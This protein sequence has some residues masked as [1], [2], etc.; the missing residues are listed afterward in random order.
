[1][2]IFVCLVVVLFL[3]A[4]SVDLSLLI[5]RQLQYFVCAHLVLNIHYNFS[6]FEP[7]RVIQRALTSRLVTA[8]EGV[9]RDIVGT[10]RRASV[11]N[12]PGQQNKRAKT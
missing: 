7:R 12:K 1:M 9:P 8:V 10:L 4:L 6:V 5:R 3:S 11:S 2:S